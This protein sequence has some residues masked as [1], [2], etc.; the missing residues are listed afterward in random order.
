[1]H[2]HSYP[3]HKYATLPVAAFTHINFVCGEYVFNHKI[4]KLF[5][6]IHVCMPN[7]F[8]FANYFQFYFIERT[9]LTPYQT[10]P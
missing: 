7:L 1:M 8:N 9:L 5:L 3:P 10:D 6:I 2:T 4:M